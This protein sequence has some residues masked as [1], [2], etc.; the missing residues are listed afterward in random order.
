MKSDIKEKLAD[1]E[2]GLAIDPDPTLT[3]EERLILVLHKFF[4]A[5]AGRKD[6]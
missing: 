3:I 5:F 6:G 2:K 1:I 4:N